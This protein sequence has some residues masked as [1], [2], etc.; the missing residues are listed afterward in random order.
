MVP[1]AGAVMLGVGGRLPTV[2]ETVSVED[3]PDWL[4]TV[5]RAVNVLTVDDV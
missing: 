5:S 1:L 3:A 4:V 2:T